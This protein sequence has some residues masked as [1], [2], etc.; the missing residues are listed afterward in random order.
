MRAFMKVTV[1]A[2]LAAAFSFPCVGL[3][4]SFEN[5]TL[6]NGMQVLLGESHSSPMVAGV[7]TI[8]AGSWLETPDVNGV[9][10]MLEH[11]LFDGT[12]S[13]SREKLTEEMRSIGGY[14]NAFTRKDYTAFVF[15]VPSDEYEKACEIQA[16]ML[17]H[18]ILPDEEVAK[19]RKVV[20]EEINKDTSTPEYLRGKF[21]DGVFYA[22]TPYAMS[23]LGEKNV[24]ETIP[25]E[26]ILDY[27]RRYYTPSNMRAIIV[28]DFDGNGI[29]RVLEDCF[30][31]SSPG[32]PAPGNPPA[33]PNP[34]GAVHVRAA[35][36]DYTYV[37]IAFDAPAMLSDDFYAF[38]VLCEMMNRSGSVLNRSLKEEPDLGV[39]SCRVDYEHHRGFSRALVQLTASSH[40]VDRLVE[41]AVKALEETASRKCDR[42]LLEGVKISLVTN[43]I[44]NEE[45][46]H[47]YGMFKADELALGGRDFLAGKLGNLERVGARDVERVAKRYLGEPRYAVAAV[48][49]SERRNSGGKEKTGSRYE[50]WTTENGLRVITKYNEDS[51]VF[52]VH[53]LFDNRLACEPPGKHGITELLSRMIMKGTEGMDEKTLEKELDRIGAEVVCTD[54]PYIP[55]DDY[56]TKEDYSFIRFQTIDKYYARGLELLSEIIL[57]PALQEKTL[58]EAKSEMKAVLASESRK[59]MQ[60]AKKLFFANLFK[61][62]PFQNGVLGDEGTLDAITLDDVKRFHARY[63]TPA[64]MILTVASNVDPKSLRKRIDEFFS[65]SPRDESPCT[66]STP[67]PVKGVVRA[68]VDVEA[69]QTSIFLGNVLP[70]VSPRD[71]AA[72]TVLNG[73]LSRRLG[74][75][76]RERRGLAYSV[77]S[78]VYFGK[79][80]ARMSVYIGTS[81][82][83]RSEA[84]KGLVEIM[85]EVREK[86][87]AGDVESYKNGFRGRMLMRRLS[88]MNQAYYMGLNEH[89]GF[90]Y[91][92]DDDFIRSVKSVTVE[93][94]RAAAAKYLPIDDHVIAV[95]GP[96]AE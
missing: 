49:P 82:E 25:R 90:G 52:A 26:R 29:K 32:V 46:Y 10:H 5:Y 74:E 56:R 2:W 84:E 67:I 43:E 30:G 45:K 89:R 18:S 12:A 85:K 31:K 87:S 48:V 63:F 37:D 83:K 58:A 57:H 39:V 73:V 81:P 35:E 92:F 15:L 60:A 66:Y 75:V 95:A 68:S 59:P 19:E 72:V 4:M 69:S 28:G 34:G 41:R 79:D 50:D 23:V 38:Q 51:R 77:G 16:D 78:S 86:A 17:L 27:Y 20:T 1:L 40:D 47:Y 21:M 11:L 9:S 13:R 70:P 44:Y 55:Y 62:H 36:G 76:L 7:I 6:S 8:A 53:V 88:R 94:V 3:A 65:G 22:G 93:Q 33:P 14:F 96:R 91:A 54:N 61:G 64:N 80:Y 71:A 24:I 42:D